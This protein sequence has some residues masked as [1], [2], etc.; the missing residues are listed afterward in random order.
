MCEELEEEL[1]EG[2]KAAILLAEHLASMGAG[3]CTI[4]VEIDSGC[5]IVE[6][7]KTL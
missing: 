1:E 5:F 3:K 7:R 6:I 2:K 4:P